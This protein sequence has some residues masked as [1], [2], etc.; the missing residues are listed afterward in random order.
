[1]TIGDP[2]RKGVGLGFQPVPEKKAGRN[3]GHLDILDDQSRVL[4]SLTASANEQLETD[5]TRA[6][7]R[8]AAERY[9][10]EAVLRFRGSQYRLRRIQRGRDVSL[11]LDMTVFEADSERQ[12][13]LE[14]VLRIASTA[15]R[16]CNEP[17]PME[18]GC[19]A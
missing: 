16:K 6:R 13:A 19:R 3:R 17:I 8:H 12:S 2:E 9:P 15:R 4:L 1:V 10:R 11:A 14:G 18:T 7:Q 5:R